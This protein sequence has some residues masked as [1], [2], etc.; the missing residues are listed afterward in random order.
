MVKLILL[1]AIIYAIYHFFIKPKPIK[2]KKKSEKQKDEDIMV[3]CAKCKTYVSSKEAI[4]KNG[5]YYCSKE[6]AKDD[7]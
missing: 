4:I 2:E 7:N 5:K 6:C 1:V 3:E